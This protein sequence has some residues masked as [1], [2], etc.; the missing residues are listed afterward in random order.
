MI[1]FKKR[2]FYRYLYIVTTSILIIML[3]S[4][5]KE[6]KLVGETE[7]KLGTVCTISLPEGTDELIYKGAFNVLDLVEKEISR[8]SETSAIS[9]LNVNKSNSFNKETYKLLQDSYKMSE[10]SN[11][12]FDPSIGLAV[13]LWDIGGINPRIPS[14]KELSEIDTNY[15]DVKFDDKNRVVSI[16]LNMEI[17]LGADGKGYSADLIREYLVS[18][19]VNKAIINLGGNILLIG[20]K[21]DNVDWVIGLQDPNKEIGNS[22]ILLSLSDTSVVTSGTYE[23]F[24]IKDGIKYHHILSPSTLYPADSDII[25]SSIISK[26]S[27]L[28]DML[29]TT[30]FI[31]GSKKAL[32]FMKKYP[33]ARAVF[34]LK[35][36][37]VV[38]SDNFD[39]DYQITNSDYSI[40]N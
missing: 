22:Y 24:F 14:T 19:N 8:T 38:F 33:Q 26:N 37:S 20:S 7:F 1:K 5:S 12:I 28:C 32:E 23:R 10:Q 30:C 11:G 39:K 17:D 31:M 18:K 16:P 9:I 2:I 13:S 34:L 29:S 27:T 21:S 35:D 36:G 25:S 40:I 15:K 6:V 3:S 4:C